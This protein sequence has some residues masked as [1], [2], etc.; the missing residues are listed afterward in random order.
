MTRDIN[1]SEW[2]QTIDGRA[3][4]VLDPESDDV[5]IDVIA[6]ALSLQCRFNGHVSR[7]Y[8]VAEH[9]CLVSE[10][11]ESWSEPHEIQ[12]VGLL[13]DASEAYL[14]DV[15]RP[16]KAVLPRY[17]ELEKRVEQAIATRFDLPFPWPSAIKSADLM[18]LA[19]EKRDLLK[20]SP[21]PWA[22]LPSIPSSATWHAHG[23]CWEKA[24]DM[25]LDRHRVL[26]AWRAA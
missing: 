8:S 25:F 3:F 14:G 15:I 21:R 9:S 1:G 23:W 13:H 18:A 22:S 6:H 26:S 10:I 5:D 7:F 17:R 24:R 19:I 4:F 20:P 2:L 12:L 16:V 11:L